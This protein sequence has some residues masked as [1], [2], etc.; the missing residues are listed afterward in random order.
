MVRVG[1]CRRSNCLFCIFGLDQ[2]ELAYPPP[3]HKQKE[4][5]K[6][7]GQTGSQCLDSGAWTRRCLHA[8]RG[9]SQAGSNDISHG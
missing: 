3:L 2:D 8:P 5:Q 6:N 7:D 4:S 1:Q 9:T